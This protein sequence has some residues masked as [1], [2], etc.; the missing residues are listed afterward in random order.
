MFT[1]GFKYNYQQITARFFQ[2]EDVKNYC[3]V[4]C[5]YS[6]VPG[7]NHVLRDAQKVCALSK[8]GTVLNEG[9]I[10][11]N[12][13]CFKWRKNKTIKTDLCEVISRWIESGLVIAD[14]VRTV[15][16]GL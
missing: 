12:F 7:L 1:V 9:N 10:R 15:I 14:T 3:L 16:W 4:I 13:G 6:D 8:V 5:C 2:L 11:R